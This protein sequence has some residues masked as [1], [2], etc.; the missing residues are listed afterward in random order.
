MTVSLIFLHCPQS[1]TFCPL[2]N[3]TIL[4]LAVFIVLI[5]K[6]RIAWGFAV[7]MYSLLHSYDQRVV[8]WSASDGPFQWVPLFFLF[9]CLGKCVPFAPSQNRTDMFCHLSSWFP[10]TVMFSALSHF[11]WQGHEENCSEVFRPVRDLRTL[12]EQTFV[13]FLKWRLGE[14]EEVVI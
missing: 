9:F 1:Q 4:I 7:L 5:F 2:A 13:S 14:E 10:V 12:P 3:I 8:L 11:R 6:N